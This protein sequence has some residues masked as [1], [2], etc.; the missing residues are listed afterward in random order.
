MGDAGQPVEIGGNV[1]GHLELVVAA[2]IVPHDLLQG[3]GQAVVDALAG[4]LV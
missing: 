3:L 2:A 1:S 4:L